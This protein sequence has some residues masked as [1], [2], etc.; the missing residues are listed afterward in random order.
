MTELAYAVVQAY[1]AVYELRRQQTAD[2]DL[3]RR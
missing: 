2:R 1:S 3:F